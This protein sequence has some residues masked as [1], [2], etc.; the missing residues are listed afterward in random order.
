MKLHHNRRRKI[1]SCWKLLFGLSF[2]LGLPRFQAASPSVHYLNLSLHW[3]KWTMSE[4]YQ[5]ALFVETFPTA[6]MVGVLVAPEGQ[7]KNAC[8][9]ETKFTLPP[10][11]EAWIAFIM[12]GGCT[13]EEKIK[14]AAQ[15]GST[16]VIIY[17][18][19]FTYKE[20][21]LLLCRKEAAADRGAIMISRLKGKQSLRLVKGGIRVTAVIE[22]G[23][24]QY[25]WKIYLCACSLIL[26]FVAYVV[27]C[28]SSQQIIARAE[29]KRTRVTKSELR[30]AVN[31]LAV[32]K[33]KRDDVHHTGETCAVCL[34]TYKPREVLRIVS[35]SH[36]F[37]KRCVDRWLLKRGS[38]PI[39]NCAILQK[40]GKR[41]H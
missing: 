10:N 28:C 22:V 40:R 4:A 9:W 24:V 35:C 29:E 8:S 26:T 19:P 13:F 41:F 6:R 2:V 16:G 20:D 17:D 39:C 27:L 3:G 14:V 1:S 36:V 5:P 38:C 18:R 7:P 23:T 15:K 21:L 12:G 30:E 34:E 32:R 25:V 37:H 33:L 31:S 11:T